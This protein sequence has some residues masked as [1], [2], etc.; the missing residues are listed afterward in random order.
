M[1]KKFLPAYISYPQDDTLGKIILADGYVSKEISSFRIGMEVLN[2]LFAN[3]KITTQEYDRL[4]EQLMAATF[5]M[6]GLSIVT[7]K[8]STLISFGSWERAQ[9]N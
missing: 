2:E 4:E 5:I 9:W 1:P 6:E 8:L 7:V 3:C